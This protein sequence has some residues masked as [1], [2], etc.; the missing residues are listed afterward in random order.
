MVPLTFLSSNSISSNEEIRVMM[1]EKLRRWF[2]SLPLQSQ[3]SAVLRHSSTPVEPP[4]HLSNSPSILT[5][6]VP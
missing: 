4:R 3:N 6:P 2:L 5:F 1:N